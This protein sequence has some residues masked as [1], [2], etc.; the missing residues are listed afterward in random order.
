[1]TP[2]RRRSPAQRTREAGARFGDVQHTVACAL[3]AWAY[4][5]QGGYFHDP[6][7]A[8]TCGAAQAR[9]EPNR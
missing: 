9:Q 2:P 6:Q 7:P 5:Q 3:S 4:E 8:C 1:M